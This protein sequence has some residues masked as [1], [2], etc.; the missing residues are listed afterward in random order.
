[1]WRK[2]EVEFYRDKA[3]R[4]LWRWRVKAR[5]GEIVASSGESFHNYEDCRSS[6]RNFARACRWGRVAYR[7][8]AP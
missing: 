3:K 8:V 5:N 6:I 7:T 2:Y 1:M 4:P